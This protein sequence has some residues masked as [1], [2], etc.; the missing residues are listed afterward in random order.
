[1]LAEREEGMES[2]AMMK[3]VRALL[4]G[5]AAAA[6][7]AGL[8]ACGTAQAQGAQQ[9]RS[10][11]EA[12]VLAKH[13]MAGLV[14]PPGA[15][16]AQVKRLP[17][18]LRRLTVTFG[19]DGRTV[20]VDGFFKLQQSMP[21][22]ARFLAAHL[23]AGT[24]QQGQIEAFPAPGKSVFLTYV[25]RSLP[26]TIAGAQLLTGVMPYGDCDSLLHV[27]AQVRWNP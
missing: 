13:L 21:K 12:L 22:A 15:K 25:P 1:L 14:L 6:A 19:R 20:E 23:P 26:T 3:R 10:R 5:A 16:P 27:T 8:T 18:P 11:A 24:R 7:L 4:A 17:R 2:T 9:A